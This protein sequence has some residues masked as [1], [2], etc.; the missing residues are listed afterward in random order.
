[1]FLDAFQGIQFIIVASIG[2]QVHSA[3]LSLAKQFE[4]E[5]VIELDRLGFL[6]FPDLLDL[7]LV[8]VLDLLQANFK[9]TTH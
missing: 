9:V 5:K 2:H 6:P 8:G 1:M 7:D 4:E 3:K